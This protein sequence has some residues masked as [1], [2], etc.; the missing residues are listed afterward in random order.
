MSF[1]GNFETKLRG[2]LAEIAPQYDWVSGWPADE[3]SKVDVAGLRNGVPAV[4]VEVE[5]KKD[6]PVE[7]VVKIWRCASEKR[8]TT[9]L[10][11][12][13]AFSAHYVPGPGS[14]PT[15]T[16]QHERAVFV[17]TRMAQD[18]SHEIR[19]EQQPIYTTT[20]GGQRKLFKP[21]MRRGVTVKQGGGAMLRAAEQLA[22]DVAKL[23]ESQPQRR[24]AAAR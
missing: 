17:G 15:K 4:L 24:A 6:N 10:L 1:A 11:F 2:T 20:R 19:Y 9:P 16:K 23:L 8:I 3:R 7:N 13:H 18:S 12:V 5:L 22:Q 14:P 21:L